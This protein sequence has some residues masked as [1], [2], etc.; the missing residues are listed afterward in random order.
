MI[1]IRA[2]TAS[3]LVKSIRIIGLLALIIY[4]AVILHD[5][6]SASMEGRLSFSA[7]E[8]NALVKYCEWILGFIGIFV[9]FDYLIRL[10]KE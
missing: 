8:P 5:W 2:F 7:G 4:M 1:G 9:A 3:R 6:I 10:L